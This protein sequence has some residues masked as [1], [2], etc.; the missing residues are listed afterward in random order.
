MSWSDWFS[1]EWLPGFCS[2]MSIHNILKTTGKSY[3]KNLYKK[4]LLSL[5]GWLDLVP[6]TDQCLQNKMTKPEKNLITYYKL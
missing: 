5:T 3:L 1:V 4:R 2:S 6:K